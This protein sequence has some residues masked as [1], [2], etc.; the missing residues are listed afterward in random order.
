MWLK[1]T[2]YCRLSSFNN[3]KIIFKIFVLVQSFTSTQ[4]S[5]YKRLQ[6]SLIPHLLLEGIYNLIALVLANMFTSMQVPA[7]RRLQPCLF[8]QGPRFINFQTGSINNIISNISAST[9]HLFN[10]LQPNQSITF[11]TINLIIQNIVTRIQ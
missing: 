6:S 8:F 4:A 1:T 3:N 2:C 11:K 10:Q 5:T 7:Y 9:N